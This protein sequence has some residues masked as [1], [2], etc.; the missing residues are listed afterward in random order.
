MKK[1]IRRIVT[2]CMI[3]AMISI[4]LPV[5]AAQVK[6][7]GNKK[8][9]AAWRNNAYTVTYDPNGGSGSMSSQQFKY[10]NDAVLAQNGY[11]RSGYEFLGWSNYIY[12]K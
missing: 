12:Y 11:S 1:E 7:D 6:F 2:M 8:F 10:D 9:S 3:A 5:Q 4:T